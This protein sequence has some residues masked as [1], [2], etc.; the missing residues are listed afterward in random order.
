M[1]GKLGKSLNNRLIINQLAFLFLLTSC[2]NILAQGPFDGW[3]K[4]K[5]KTDFAFSFNEENYDTYLFGAAKRSEKNQIQSASL[6]L[7]HGFNDSLGLVITIPYLRTPTCENCSDYNQ[8]IQD[9]IIGLKYRIFKEKEKRGYLKSFTAV[10][11][12]FP[13]SGYDSSIERPLG[14]RTTSFLAKYYVQKDYFNGL[15]L[16]FQTGLDIR[17]IPTFQTSFPVMG[18]MGWSN[19]KWF[20]EGWGE[21]FYTFN[22]GVDTQVFGGSGSTW[23]KLG[24]TIYYSILPNFGVYIKSAHIVDG[25]NI[26]LSNTFGF[27]MAYRLRWK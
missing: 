27:G 8:G 25:T 24:A 15:F 19:R 3:M 4:G 18:K 1:P 23:L 14:A 22:P 6:F 21:Y 16:H 7:E 10:G 11:L 5:N 26:G 13:A 20:F 17:F 12:S 9:A 2:S